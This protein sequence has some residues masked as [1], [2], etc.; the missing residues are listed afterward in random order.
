[1][2]HVF[3]VLCRLYE[4]IAGQSEEL[5]QLVADHLSEEVESQITEGVRA[6]E[7]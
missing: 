6:L 1:M 2:N 3:P 5:R 4:L 7:V